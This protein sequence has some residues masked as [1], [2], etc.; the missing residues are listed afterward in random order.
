MPLTPLLSLSRKAWVKDLV[1]R[2]PV[3][4]GVVS[5]F[6]AGEDLDEL[7]AVLGPL[8]AD[9][10]TATVD[11]L[12]EDTT[13]P[14][15]ADE[16]TAEYL[17]LLQRLSEAG[18]CDRVEVS[19]KPTAIGQLLPDD[20][21]RRALRNAR[22]ICARARELGTTV[23][24][25]MEDH[26]TTDATLRLVRE[27]RVAYPW[28]GCVLQAM[29]RRT[30]DDIATMAG[31]GC[32]TRLCKGAYAC[33]PD[34]AHQGATAVTVAYRRNLALLMRL[35]GYPMVATHDPMMITLAEAFADVAQRGPGD[36]EHQMLYGI[37]TTEQRRLVATGHQVRVYVPYGTDWYGYFMRRLAER[38]ANLLFFLRA[39]VSRR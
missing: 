7:I 8:V 25:D 31:D 14:E 22:T 10:R 16:T 9:G 1:M 32:R 12:G 33:P 30:P 39:M 3:T 20:G 18:L 24:V 15:Q 27:L 19:L 34:V 38:P 5:R 26:T 17:R 28:V 23:T 21:E 13:S 35:P 36:Y 4:R 29:L 37:R 11:Y 6:V 2:F